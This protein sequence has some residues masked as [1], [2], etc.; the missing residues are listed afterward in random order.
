MAYDSARNRTVLFGGGDFSSNLRGDTWEWDGKNWTE[1][2]LVTFDSQTGD[3]S[4][5]SGNKSKSME[6]SSE[7]L[8]IV[9]VLIFFVT[10]VMQR[11]MPNFKD[12][13]MGDDDG[14]G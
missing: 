8:V 7:L 1:M 12:P 3:L 14:D 6:T 10:M 9:L 11:K 4:S 13:P 2:Y 5:E